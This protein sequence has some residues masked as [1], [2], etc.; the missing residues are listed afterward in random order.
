VVITTVESAIDYAPRWPFDDEAGKT[1]TFH[2]TFE[3]K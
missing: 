1:H 3:G 2:L